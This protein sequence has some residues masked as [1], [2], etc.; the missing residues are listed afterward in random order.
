[1]PTVNP[2]TISWTNPTT[3]TDVTG[4]TVPF[5]ATA[6][7]GGIEIQLDG[8]GAVSVPVSLG[9]TSFDLTTLAAYTALTVGSHT[10][11]LAVV[12]KEGAAS[13]FAPPLTFLAA[14]KPAVPTAV[15]LA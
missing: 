6:D 4:A 15:A 2:K 8:V 5:D 9:A 7:L 11:G 12:S 3:G 14:V 1:M 10:V 13:D